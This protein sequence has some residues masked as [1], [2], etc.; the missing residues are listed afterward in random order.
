VFGPEMY[1]RSQHQLHRMMAVDTHVFTLVVERNATFG[2][3]LARCTE[4]FGEKPIRV[5]LCSHVWW[6][7]WHW[8]GFFMENFG[9]SLPSVTQ[10]SYSYHLYSVVQILTMSLY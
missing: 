9:C 3:H 6:T 10:I 7:K 1:F 2:I 4:I 8:D 5:P